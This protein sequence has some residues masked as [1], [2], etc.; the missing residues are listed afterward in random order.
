MPT[1]EFYCDTY[2]GDLFA[3]KEE[4]E[5]YAKRAFFLLS[6]YCRGNLDTT[7]ATVKTATCLQA[8]FLMLNGFESSIEGIS[9]GGFTVGKVRI[10]GGS[11]SKSTSMGDWLKYLS[12]LALNLIAQ[13]GN[14]ARHLNVA[15]D[16]FIWGW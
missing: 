7:S 5:K 9:E 1:Y 11:S 8:D 10:D 14:G 4:F 16:P 13:T 12:P 3:S 6:L 2:C 15:I